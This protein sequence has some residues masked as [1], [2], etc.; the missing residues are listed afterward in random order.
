MTAAAFAQGGGGGGGGAR[1]GL[2]G[3]MFGGMLTT[4]PVYNQLITALG[5][6]NLDPGF[7][8]S[9]EQKASLKKIRDDVKAA[10]TK[11]TTDHAA[12]ITK[13]Q[14]DAQDAM[15]NGG[16]FQDIMPRITDLRNTMPKTDDAQAAI[17]KLLTA[18]QQKALDAKIAEMPA[19][20]GFGGRG[21]AGGGGGGG[22]GGI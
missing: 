17:K 7:T 22:G 4:D 11:W 1:G 5:D 15:T 2:G 19:A 16:G 20:R 9:S 21:G 8:L 12:D 10:Q 3:G 14:Q 13:L 18:D 6:C